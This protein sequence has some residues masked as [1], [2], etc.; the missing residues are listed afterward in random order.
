MLAA[1]SVSSLS[2]LANGWRQH[3]I[4]GLIVGEL[5]QRYGAIDFHRLC[6]KLCH[7]VIATFGS[8]LEP[9]YEILFRSRDPKK[10]D[11]EAL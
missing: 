8:S 5:S 4:V 11:Q 7:V 2:S 9:G 6:V 1:N 10:K 3:G